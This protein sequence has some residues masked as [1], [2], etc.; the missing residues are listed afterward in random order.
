MLSEIENPEFAALKSDIE[1]HP[2]LCGYYIL[3]LVAVSE[4]RHAGVPQETILLKLVDHF[5]DDP[6]ESI[7]GFVPDHEWSNYETTYDDARGHVVE[8]LTGGP[9]IGHTRETMSRSTAAELFDR[10]VAVCGANPRF[11]VGLG[12]G[13]RKYSFMYGALIVADDLAGILWIVEDD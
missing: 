11:Y 2:R 12:I 7:P 4:W 6:T 9:Q 1:S 10:F 3:G 13:D 8:S 5:D